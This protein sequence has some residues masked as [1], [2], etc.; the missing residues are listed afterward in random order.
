M[1]KRIAQDFQ[2]VIT[3]ALP[4]G[5]AF[6]R[7]GSPN[8]DGIVGAV[9]DELAAEDA[10]TAKMV[11]ESNPATTSDMLPEWEAD[12]GLP[13]CPDFAPVSTP[14]RLAELVTKITR[15][16][17][18]NPQA[19]KAL[20]NDL[21]FD[22]EVIE[23][24][25]FQCGVSQ[26]GDEQHATTSPD[27]RFWLTVKVLGDRA[28]RFHCGVS[29]CGEKLLTITPAEALECKLPQ[30]NHAHMKLTFAYEE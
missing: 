2:N 3:Q 26:C 24:R 10:L 16:A 28:T 29:R 12:Y 9:A 5:P 20:C 30:V 17:S 19:I 6:P 13:D 14:D 25:P 18:Y 11:T 1:T 8:R 22:V 27:S 23:R 21:G 15:V 4:Q 7:E